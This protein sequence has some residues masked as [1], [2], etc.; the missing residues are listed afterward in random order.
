MFAGLERSFEDRYHRR[1]KKTLYIGQLRVLLEDRFFPWI[2][3][4]AAM[5]LVQN[6][7]LKSNI[8]STTYVEKV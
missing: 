8:V 6:G 3:Y 7:H 4:N 1:R 2:V 5:G